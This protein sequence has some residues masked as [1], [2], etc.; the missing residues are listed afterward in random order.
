MSDRASKQLWSTNKDLGGIYRIVA[1]GITGWAQQRLTLGM[2]TLAYPLIFCWR[3]RIIFY[4]KS[5]VTAK[6]P[7]KLSY[8]I[9]LISGDQN[10]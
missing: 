5:E 1:R 4:C 8:N 9:V 3:N 2:S 7:I 10:L 6:I